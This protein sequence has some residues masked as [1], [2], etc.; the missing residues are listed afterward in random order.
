MLD[1][2]GTCWHSNNA[3]LA[4]APFHVPGFCRMWRVGYKHYCNGFV[5][6]C[7]L[8][9]LGYVLKHLHSRALRRAVNIAKPQGGQ[10]T[11]DLCLWGEV[12]P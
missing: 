12:P 3:I 4:T 6:C 5:N 11:L 8:H 10:V 7:F 2:P 9:T 1:T